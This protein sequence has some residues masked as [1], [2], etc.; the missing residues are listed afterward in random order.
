[1]SGFTAGMLVKLTRV[2]L[3]TQAMFLVD[4]GVIS[5]YF[6]EVSQAVLAAILMSQV[7]RRHGTRLNIRPARDKKNNNNNKIL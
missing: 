4:G 2:Q 5:L 1:M 7:L 6:G 3:R